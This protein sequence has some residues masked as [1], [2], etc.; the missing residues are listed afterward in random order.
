V[1]TTSRESCARLAAGITR[2][3][4]A[5]AADWDSGEAKAM[6]TKQGSPNIPEN[7]L[8]ISSLSGMPLDRMPL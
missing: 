7:N 6:T 3:D 8:F 4:E 1:R 5:G 2:H